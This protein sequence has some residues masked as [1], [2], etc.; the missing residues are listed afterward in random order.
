MPTPITTLVRPQKEDSWLERNASGAD[1]RATHKGP[2]GLPLGGPC[3]ADMA[4]PMVIP[5]R[6]DQLI[7]CWWC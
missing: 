2:R 5:H 3:D 6:Q 4:S 1:A 7:L